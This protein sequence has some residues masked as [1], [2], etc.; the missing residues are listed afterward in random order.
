MTNADLT[1]DRLD[2]A[3]RDLLFSRARTANTFAPTPVSDED[4]K[5][6]WDLA[7]WPPTG[8]NT[9]PMRVVFVRTLQGKVRLVSHMFEGNV[10]KTN[11]APVAAILAKD[12]R[13]HEHIP[14]VL[15]F[16]PEMKELFESMPEMR[17]KAGSLSAALQAAYFIM[18]VRATGLAAGPMGGFNAAALDADFFSDGRLQSFLVV[19]IGHPGEDPWFD[20]LPRLDHEQVLSWA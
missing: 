4:L 14:T 3:G 17:E 8:G 10:A 2:Q 19:N 7:K 12:T 6:I 13:F 11:A 15:P 9:Q 18:A 16:R 20:R 5:S 1:L